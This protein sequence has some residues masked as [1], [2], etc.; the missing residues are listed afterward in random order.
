MKLIFENVSLD[1]E[2]EDNVEDDE[3]EKQQIRKAV[4]G[5]QV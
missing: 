3:W 2:D 5:A 1:G 4:T